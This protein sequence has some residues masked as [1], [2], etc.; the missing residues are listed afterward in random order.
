[1]ELLT[2][3]TNLLSMNSLVN[4]TSGRDIGTEVELQL[5]KRERA[6]EGVAETAKE[7]VRVT[8]LQL[9]LPFQPPMTA[10]LSGS[11]LFDKILVSIVKEIYWLIF[12]L[13]DKSAVQK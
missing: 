4:F 2:E 11:T 8:R 3:S 5:Q 12:L 13:A 7:S 6:A 1:M 10:W 9:C